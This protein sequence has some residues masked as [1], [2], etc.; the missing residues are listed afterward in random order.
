MILSKYIEG[1][2]GMSAYMFNPIEIDL[3]N[4]KAS[5]G[6]GKATEQRCPVNARDWGAPAGV[7]MI[8]PLRRCSPRSVSHNKSQLSP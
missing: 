4:V 7:D 8:S 2:A 1:L 3:M 5:K 6:Q